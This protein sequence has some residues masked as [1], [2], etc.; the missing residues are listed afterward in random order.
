[1]TEDHVKPPPRRIA[2][3]LDA[4]EQSLRVMAIAADIAAALQAELEG[5]FVEDAGLLGAVGLPFQREFRLATRGES[6]IEPERLQRELRAAARWMR[7]SLEQS[8]QRLGCSWSFRVWR[9]DL[10]AEILSAASGAEMFT[11]SRIG[12]FAPFR[13]R[14]PARAGGTA[15]GQGGTR[16]VA[17]PAALTL[18]LLFDGSAGARRALAA[19][20]ELAAGGRGELHIILR[21]A[22]AGELAERRRLAL[23]LL[24][25]AAGRTSFILLQGGDADDVAGSMLRSGGD[26][27]LIDAGNRLLQRDS[28]WKSLAALDCPMLVIR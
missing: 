3:A 20:V 24:G 25:S 7:Q 9:G 12:R 2:V 17:S 6:V 1:M 8:A 23:E 4:S 11:L 22:D 28:L 14:A 21:G 19:A 26:V 27:F 16:G 10:Q 15:G 5:V 18:S 13:Q